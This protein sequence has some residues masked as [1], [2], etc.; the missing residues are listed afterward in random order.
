MI[1]VFTNLVPMLEGRSSIGRLGLFVLVTAGFGDIWFGCG[2]EDHLLMDESNTQGATWTLEIMTIHP[3]RI[4]K[5]VEVW[6][7]VNRLDT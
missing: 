5:F 7:T 3:L 6:T 2:Q 1:N 4:Y